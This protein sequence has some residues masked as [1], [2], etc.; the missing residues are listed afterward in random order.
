MNKEISVELTGWNREEQ[1]FEFDVYRAGTDEVLASYDV[2]NGYPYCFSLIE[3]NGLQK[4][5]WSETAD[6]ACAIAD[7]KKY[8]ELVEGVYLTDT[9]GQARGVGSG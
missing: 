5:S 8:F 9:H 2:K 6:E 7:N 3:E 4:E 1:I